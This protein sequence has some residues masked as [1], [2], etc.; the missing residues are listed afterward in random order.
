MKKKRVAEASEELY[1][2][3]YLEVREGAYFW[4]PRHAI[5][6]DA[7]HADLGTS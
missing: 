4:P 7:I 5:Q 1:V 2:D 6:R 3:T